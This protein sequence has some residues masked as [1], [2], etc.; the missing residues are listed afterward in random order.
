MRRSR[1][2][3]IFVGQVID[4]LLPMVVSSIRWFYLNTVFSQNISARNTDK[5]V[6]ALYQNESVKS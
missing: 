2:R 6:I 5:V 1:Q 3:N 4:N